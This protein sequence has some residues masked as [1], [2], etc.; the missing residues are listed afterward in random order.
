MVHSRNKGH[1]YERD[2]RRDLEAAG[3]CA[4]RGD[5]S[6]AGH[7]EPDIKTEPATVLV[8]CNAVRLPSL[9]VECKNQKRLP[10]V[11]V[12]AAFRQAESCAGPGEVPVVV[13]HIRG[14]G[15]LALLHWEDLINLSTCGGQP[16]SS[17]GQHGDTQQCT[18]DTS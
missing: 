2:R 17:Y 6:R 10:G 16:V 18:S 14:G 15:D 13:F 12:L 11:R 7:N 3:F 5:Q 9:R 8:A 4:A 1:N